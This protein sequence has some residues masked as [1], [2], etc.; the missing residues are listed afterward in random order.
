MAPSNKGLQAAHSP[1]HGGFGGTVLGADDP[2]SS[3]HNFPAM[4]FTIFA[5]S[6]GLISM[7]L[8]IN[9]KYWFVSDTGSHMGLFKL[10]R[11]DWEC[12][13]TC[14]MIEEGVSGDWVMAGQI[15][16]LAGLLSSILMLL[17]I[18]FSCMNLTES[19]SRRKAIIACASI[20]VATVTA[21]V[22]LLAYWQLTS[23]ARVSAADTPDKNGITTTWSVGSSYLGALMAFILCL[24]GAVSA[25]VAK[26]EAED[27]GMMAAVELASPNVKY[28]KG[29]QGPG[30]ANKY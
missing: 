14:P 19:T 12:G 29:R 25:V 26:P 27:E 4:M 11:K 8:A 13:D 23:D 15:T 22:A 9:T 30:F 5:A 3:G 6:A 20:D 1:N 28:K 17:S 7:M 18:V 24:A 2:R 21:I 16:F 10:V